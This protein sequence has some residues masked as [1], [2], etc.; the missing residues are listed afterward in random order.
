MDGTLVDSTAGV[1][2]AWALFKEKY[3][4]IDIRH[5]L[6]S[7]FNIRW[8][9]ADAQPI[10]ACHGVRTVET[11]RTVCKVEDPVELQ[12]NALRTHRVNP[13]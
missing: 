7:E 1:E 13:G 11:L 4:D 10:I 2:G 8:R 5:V 9:F 3:T 12:V 6:S